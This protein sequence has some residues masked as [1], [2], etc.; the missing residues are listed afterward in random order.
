MKRTLI[1]YI[2]LVF[3]LAGIHSLSA[4]NTLKIEEIE[5]VNLGDG[6]MY[7]HKRDADKTAVD[8][9][10][11]IIT[12][13]TTEY[14]DANFKKGYAEG[15]WDYY[16]SNKLNAYMIY[17]NGYLNGEC[18]ELYP[19]GDQKET[20]NYKT[21]KKDGV[22]KQ[23]YGEGKV[24]QQEEY[25][26]GEIRKITQYYPDG[27]LESE[28]NFLNR[29]E[30]GAEKHYDRETGKLKTE[31]YYEN[32]KQV[33]KQTQYISSNRNDY[34]QVS[35]YSKEGKLDGK[36]TETYTET[37]KIKA[38]GQY[39]DGKKTGVWKYGKKDGEPTEE[40]TYEAGDLRKV[41]KYYTDG[42]IESERSMLNGKK[43]G[44]EKQYDWESGRLKAEKNYENGKQ[45]GRQMQYY[46]SSTNSYVQVSNYSKE[47][48]LD[49]KFTETYAETDK[50]KIQG[51]YNGGKKMG[52]WKYGYKNG[53][54]YKEE[55]YEDGKLIETKKIE[56]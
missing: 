14:I 26:D 3:V 4:Q 52:V 53:N 2:S 17:T 30:H 7:V 55:K 34:V 39:K 1:L 23:Y 8:G 29:K 19:D 48:K 35:N 44:V 54:I 33:G 41:I 18:A 16:R 9:K 24:K 28:R 42:S 15:R 49:G 10:I 32:G 37:D 40:E 13:Y 45:V 46:T 50:I 22:W 11:R 25:K 20:G 56:N 47:S 51:Q 12:G 43:H 31:K 38:Q 5:M 6:Q 21:G 27:K 36:F